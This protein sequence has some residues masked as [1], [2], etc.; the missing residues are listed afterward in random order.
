MKTVTLP[1]I[2]SGL[3]ELFIDCLK[4]DPSKSND[5]YPILKPQL[6][7]EFFLSLNFSGKEDEECAQSFN[8]MDSNKEN[9]YLL[10]FE[11]NYNTMK[12]KIVQSSTENGKWMNVVKLNMPDLK[13]VNEVF[14]TLTQDKYY[15]VTMNGE[16]MI[17]QY[18][19][20]LERMK[21]FQRLATYQWGSCLILDLEKS[22]Q[23]YKQF[24][25]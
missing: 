25:G 24:P 5:M 6:G 16:R 15:Q 14:V 7:T 12:R 8:I 19:L 9:I 23:W 2:L 20:Y 21:N 18:P 22:Y 4:G 17:E 1:T 10:K 3:R 13:T 11:I